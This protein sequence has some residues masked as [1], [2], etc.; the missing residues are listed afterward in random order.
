MANI[1]ITGGNDGIGW[2][3][4]LQFL[5][6]G[7]RVTVLDV[8]TDRLEELARQYPDTLFV[9]AGDVADEEAIAHCVTEVKERWG[10][11]D[12]AVHNACVCVFAPF[13]ETSDADMRCV[14]DVNFGGAVNLARYALPLMKAQK[15]GRLCFVSSGV[16]VMGFEGLTAYASSKGAIE[17]LARCLDIECAGTGVN[18]RLLHPPLTRTASSSPLPVPPQMMADP[19]KVGRGLARRIGKKGFIIC[20]SAGQQLQT[21][22]AYLFSLKLGR[23]LSRMTRSAEEDSQQKS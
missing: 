12:I 5:E 13:D 23:L 16:G 22:M 17:A 14:H 21:R 9:C 19:E 10:S 1:I 4:T 18:V 11:V 6:D 15:S 3:M 7:Q 2:H 8:R 20:H